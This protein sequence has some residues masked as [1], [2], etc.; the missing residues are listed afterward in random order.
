MRRSHLI[1]SFVAQD[2]R[3]TC[4]TGHIRS[5]QTP[6]RRIQDSERLRLL[7]DDCEQRFARWENTF[8]ERVYRHLLENPGNTVEYDSWMGRFAASIAWRVVR[9]YQLVKALPEPRVA[10]ERAEETWRAFLLGSRENVGPHELHLLPLDVVAT[11]P[12]P[13]AVRGLER[14]SPNWNRYCL[15]TM[16]YDLPVADSRTSA[17]VYVKLP[18]FAFFGIATAGKKSPFISGTKLT[19]RKGRIGPRC[20][21][22]GAG[23]LNYMSDKAREAAQM[24]ASLSPTQKEVIQLAI[25]HDRD[26][27]VRSESLRA[28]K[29]D[30]EVFG[31][32]AFSR[33]AERSD[34]GIGAPRSSP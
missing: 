33:P 15:T 2:L 7:C 4:G 31:S 27:V 34:E 32:E 5:N 25:A 23:V 30:I 18:R 11:V 21:K 24:I 26:R 9:R 20:Y 16:G 22:I 10:F 6:N 28:M 13:G 1:P 3:A 12:R 17:F 19:M 14:I 29:A 8:A